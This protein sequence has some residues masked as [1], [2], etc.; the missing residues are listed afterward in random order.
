M[1]AES[2]GSTGKTAPPAR[3]RWNVAFQG[4]QKMGRS[5]QL[6]IAVLPA[7]GI[8]NRLGQ[9]DVFGD[10]GLGWTAVSKVMKGAGGALLDGSLGLP[11]LF[12]VG[13][14][15]GMAR[16]SDGSTALAAVAGFLVYYTVLQQ[17]PEACPGGAKEIKDVG[18]Q[19]VVR[20]GADQVT[21]FVF[22]NPGVFGGIVMGLLTAFFWVRFHRTR[23]VDWLGFFNGRRLVPIIMSF[24]AI[25]F[26]VLCLW[27]WPPVGGALESF[28]QW[29][30]DAGSWGAGLFGVANRALLVIG[31]HQFLNVP[32]WFQFGS[33]IK[34]DGTVVHGDINMFLQGDPQAGQFTSGFFP[35]MMFALPAAALAITHCARPER[36]KEVGG[37]MLSVALTSFVTGITEPLEYSFL[38]I[39]PALY[40]VH[41]VLTGVS[42]AVTWALGVHDGF[43]FSAGLI[44][45]VINWQLATKPWLIVPIGLCFAAVYYA[46]FRFAITRFDLKTPGREPA[47]VAQEMERDNVK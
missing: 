34:P 19:V 40:A 33:Y 27:V 14:A 45:Y 39:A 31:L 6:P 25:V 17:F 16:K 5:L 12:C 13:V 9:P 2:A 20:T 41:A 42:M 28:S 44:D 47:E 4:L 23:L 32:I 35:I 46:V 26:A 3:E 10:D 37:L 43:S 11:L 36:R 18:C 24:V 8:L 1:S 21:P 15:I 30:R 38:F 22:Q 7:A 29:L